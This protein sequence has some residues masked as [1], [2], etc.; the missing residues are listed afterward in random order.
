MGLG[1]DRGDAICPYCIPSL[2]YA[3]D[4]RI[5]LHRAN[6]FIAKGG[7]H[8]PDW[9]PSCYQRLGGAL[10]VGGAHVVPPLLDRLHHYSRKFGR[11]A[12]SC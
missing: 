7:R 12:R 3:G 1:Q 2:S 8:L 6:L 11:I 4:D 5:S 10:A 9:L